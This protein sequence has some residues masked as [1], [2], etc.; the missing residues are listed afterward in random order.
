MEPAVF[1]FPSLAVGSFN[2]GIGI[3]K[4]LKKLRPIVERR[5][6][7]SNKPRLRFLPLTEFAK[8]TK[9]RIKPLYGKPSSFR[10]APDPVRIREL[11]AWLGAKAGRQVGNSPLLPR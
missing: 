6:A 10:K 4:L 3:F 8:F 5:S 9:H 11:V 2:G 1:P 7:L